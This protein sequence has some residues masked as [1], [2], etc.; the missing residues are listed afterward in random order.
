MKPTRRSFLA[1]MGILGASSP[2]I[3][4]ISAPERARLDGFQ[5]ARRHPM[6]R[7]QPTPD[8]FEGFLMGNGDIGVCLTVRPDALGLHIGKADVWDIRVSKD[9]MKDVLPFAEVRKRWERFDENKQFFQEYEVKARASYAKSWPRPWPCGILWMHWDPRAVRVDRQVLDPSDGVATIEIEHDNR[10]GTVRRVKIVCFVSQESGHVLVS[11]SEPASFLSSV[12]YYPYFDSEAQMPAPELS[13]RFSEGFG[14]FTCHQLLPCTAPTDAEPNPPPSDQDASFNLCGRLIGEWSAGVP[15]GQ[16]KRRPEYTPHRVLLEGR[17]EQPLRLDLALLTSRDDKGGMDSAIRLTERVAQMPIAQLRAASEKR[18]RQFWSKSA[19]EFTDRELERIW[20]HNQYFLACCLREGKTAPGL[21]GNWTSMHIGTAWHGDIH[22]D[23]N[24]AQ[25]YWGVFSSNHAEQHLP[26]VDFLEHVQPL[27]KSVARDHFQLPGA[28]YPITLFPTVVPAEVN[29][30]PGPPWF[31]II[32]DAPWAVQSLWWHYLYTQD[33]EFLQRVY[34][35]MAD[36]CRFLAAYATKGEDG[37]YHFNPTVS[38]ENWG[39]TQDFRLNRDAIMDLSLGAF[40]LK[41]TVEAS[42]QLNLDPDE[43]A[44]W[45]EVHDHLAPY[46]KADGPFGDVWLDVLDAPVEHVYNVPATTTPIFPAEQ[47]GISLH[48][49]QLEIARRTAKTIRLEGGND[50]VY[51]PLTRARLGM[52]DLEW[53]KNE[54]RY[55]L[56]PND[57]CFD[58]ARQAGGR[59]RDSTDFD[60]MRRMGIWIE[61]FSL[62]AVLNECL[63][64]SY[65]G[66]IRLFP[67][68]TNLGGATFTQ[69]RAAGAFLVDAEWDGQA[70]ISPVLILSEKGSR[71]RLANPWPQSTVR[72]T[73]VADGKEVVALGSEGILDFGTAPGERYHVEKV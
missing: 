7:N 1:T 35:M 53:F 32:C 54:V 61:N 44:K 64:Q 31:Y 57:A 69:L 15:T 21:F 22:L 40:I 49:E 50:L 23:Y 20:Y 39:L 6:I 26:Y 34:P 59:Y 60:F 62:P 43:R 67:N 16:E 14:E 8:F 10:H 63:M 58:R 68:T 12:A 48:P 28:F 47:V 3:A 65:T 73:R 42:K 71:C 55:S 51:Q 70:V 38:A 29:P 25:V 18:W 5:L 19:V 66:V 33:R 13:S 24:N 30:Y 56:L 27:V 45:A 11:T 72:I 36:V 9:H 17:Q 2:R 41:A 37:R 52:L 4:G 46:P